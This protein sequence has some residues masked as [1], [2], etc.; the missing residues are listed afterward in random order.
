MPVTIGTIQTFPHAEPDKA[1][2]QRNRK[3]GRL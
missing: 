2:E 1:C 3:R